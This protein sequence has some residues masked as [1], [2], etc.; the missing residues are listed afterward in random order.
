M[1]PF[2]EK[3]GILMENEYELELNKNISC[4]L[5]FSAPTRRMT[6]VEPAKVPLIELFFHGK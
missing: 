1:Y 3:N 2:K 4:L 5:W 6:E